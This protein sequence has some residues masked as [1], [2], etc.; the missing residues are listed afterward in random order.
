MSNKHFNV[1]V[2]TRVQPNSNIFRPITA[3]KSLHE[4]RISYLKINPKR[5]IFG[6]M[7]HPRLSIK[8]ELTLRESN[9]DFF[10]RLGNGKGGIGK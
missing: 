10:L 1:G 9:V 5:Y 2:L 7:S 6:E 3:F 4:F 8:G